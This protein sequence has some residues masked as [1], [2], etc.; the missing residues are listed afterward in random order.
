MLLCFF[1][2]K[3]LNE[4]Q[5]LPS[6]IKYVQEATVEIFKILSVNYKF[7]EIVLLR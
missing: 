6:E 1:K 2:K 5:Y 4:I 3:Q 7:R